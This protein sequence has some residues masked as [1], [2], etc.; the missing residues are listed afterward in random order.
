MHSESTE[1]KAAAGGSAAPA[2]QADDEL[3]LSSGPGEAAPSSLQPGDWA[4]ESSDRAGLRL[5][6]APPGESG[7]LGTLLVN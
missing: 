6:N 7:E 1:L 4:G 3:G 5:P 2:R